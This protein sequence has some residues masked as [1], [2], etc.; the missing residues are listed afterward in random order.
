[1]KQ[2]D[3]KPE[4]VDSLPER[5]WSVKKAMALLHGRKGDLYDPHGMIPVFGIVAVDS[6][7]VYW[8]VYEDADGV[9]K[10]TRHREPQV[11]LGK[12]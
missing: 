12:Q 4:S 3:L 11:V 2:C 8:Q 5:E 1:M 7:G 6:D 9:Y 10:D